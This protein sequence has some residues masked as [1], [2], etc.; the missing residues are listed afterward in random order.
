MK[1]LLIGV[2]FLILIL[3]MFSNRNVK[4]KYIKVKHDSISVPLMAQPGTCGVTVTIN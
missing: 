3:Y 1:Y 2:I 4:T